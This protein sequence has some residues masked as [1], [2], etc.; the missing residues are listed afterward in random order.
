PTFKQ[1][2]KYP[3]LTTCIFCHTIKTTSFYKDLN[4]ER[5]FIVCK[6]QTDGVEVRKMF[7]IREMLIFN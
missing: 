4:T 6:Q 7:N 2:D 3:F 5:V 1:P